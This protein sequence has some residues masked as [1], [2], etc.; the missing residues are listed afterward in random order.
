LILDLGCGSFPKGDVNVDLFLA[1]IQSAEKLPIEPKKIKNFVLADAH[2]LPFRDDT[3]TIVYSSHVLEHLVNPYIALKEFKR[4]SRA[5]VYINVPSS[6]YPN[7]CRYHLY[8]WDA[9]TLE[10][11]L[12]MVFPHVRVYSTEKVAHKIRRKGKPIGLIGDLLLSLMRK[13][14]HYLF[15]HDQ[16]TAVCYKYPVKFV[17]TV[18]DRR[19]MIS[20]VIR[21]IKSLRRFVNKEHIIVFYTPPRSKKSYEK[22][23]R[24]AIVKKVPNVT[25]PFVF[26]KAIGESR[27]GEKVH[28]CDVDCPNVV[29]LDADTIVKKNPLNL[30]YGNFDFSARPGNANKDFDMNVWE[31]MFAKFGAKPIPMPNTGFMIFKNWCHKEIKN[32]WLKLINSDL[33]NPHPKNYLKE[34]YALAIALA[35]KRKRIRWMTEREHAFRWLGETNVDTYV[36]HG[37][38]NFKKELKTKIR[39]TLRSVLKQCWT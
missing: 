27:Y 36:L 34:Q 39:R 23:S 17:Y 19:N 11:L 38:R 3:F 4:V 32:L 7:D 37:R 8:R 5:V 26:S 14:R 9:N 21:S 22:L 16:L 12:K 6:K 35:V 20:D 33:P 28:L 29:F 25:K 30:V 1:P 31:G 24:L 2:Y 10:H 15:W 13:F 18:S